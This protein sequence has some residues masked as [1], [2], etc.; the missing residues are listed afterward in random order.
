MKSFTKNKVLLTNGGFCDKMQAHK[1]GLQHYAYSIFIF[2]ESGRLLLQQRALTKYHS[3]GLW[4]NT[5]CSHP[6]D[7]SDITTIKK[8]AIER[9]NEEMGIACDLYS[10]TIFT[11]KAICGNL[12]ENEIDYIFYSHTNAISKINSHEV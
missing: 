12:V 11:Y 1:L 2:D 4:S 5:C 7:V 3:G 8:Q 10:N 6:L 9:L